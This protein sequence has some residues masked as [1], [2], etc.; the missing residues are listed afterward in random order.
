M[1]P[2]AVG[3][4]AALSDRWYALRYHT[5][6]ARLK[7]SRARFNV[8]EAGRRSGKTELAKRDAVERWLYSPVETGLADYFCGFFAPT[9]DQVR[10]IYW[11]DAK[12]M[13]PPEFVAKIRETDLEIH[14]VAGPVLAC[15]GM[16]KPARAEGRPIDHAKIDEFANMKPGVWDRHL[17]PALSTPGRLGGAWIYGV[18]RPSAQFQ[19][20]AEIAQQDTTGEW[21][22]FHWPASEILPAEEIEAAKRETDELMFEQEYGAKRVPFSGRAYYAF[23]RAVHTRD[24]LPYSPDATLIFCLDFNREP[25]SAVICQEGIDPELGEVTYVLGEVHIPRDSTTPLVCRKLLADW[26]EHKGPVHYHGDPTGGNKGTAKVAGSDWDL[27]YDAFKAGFKGRA[28]DCVNRRR[29]PERGRINALN[30][31]LRNAAGEIHMLIERA[32]CPA[33]IRDLDNVLVLKGSD[34]ALDKT[35]TSLTHWTDGLGYYCE[36]EHPISGHM[37]TVESI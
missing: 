17:R 21:D 9:R 19:R 31:R 4:T 11:E 16:D 8:V 35:D 14:H 6:Q 23:D 10:H 3:G 27:V 36:D 37:F 26:G 28:I 12:A 22:Y 30:M 13:C 18:P 24:G 15:V 32:R 5:E 34:G 1:C 7:A 2:A 25:G 33:L 20:L 29:R